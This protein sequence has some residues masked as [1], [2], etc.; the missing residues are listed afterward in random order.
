MAEPTMLDAH[1]RPPESMRVWFKWIQKSTPEDLRA[2]TD[3]LDFEALQVV[4][5]AKLNRYEGIPA[6][7]LAS[8][9]TDFTGPTSNSYPVRTSRIESTRFE[10]KE[11]PGAPTA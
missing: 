2:S 7:K 3:I 6:S 5:L 9:F 11:L 8:M 1:Q 4:H 10:L